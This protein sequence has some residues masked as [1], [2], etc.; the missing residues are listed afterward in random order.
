MTALL[1]FVLTFALSLLGF[2]SPVENEVIQ[3]NYVPH[4]QEL[5]E[6]LD[7]KPDKYCDDILINPCFLLK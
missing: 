2:T 4:D 3:K 6:I 7:I 1:K 5:T